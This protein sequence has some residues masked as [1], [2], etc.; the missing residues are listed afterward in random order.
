MSKRMTTTWR[1]IWLALVISAGAL[2]FSEQAL[3]SESI[4]AELVRLQDQT[5]LTIAW[6]DNN[7][8]SLSFRNRTPL[9]TGVRAVE[10]KKRAV[11]PLKDSLSAFRL[12]GF[13]FDNFPKFAADDFCWSH[14]RSMV[15]ATMLDPP[16]ASLGIFVLNSKLTQ[17][18]E[19]RAD[20]RM[21][22]TSQCWSPD[23]KEVTYEL[24][25]NVKIYQ[26]GSDASTRIRVLAKGTDVTWSPDGNWIAFRDHDTYY[27]I[28][29]D[30]NGRKELFRNHWGRAVSALYWS[31]DSRIVAY[32][33]EL[34][35][36]QG[37]ALDAEVNQSGLGGWMMGRTIDCARIAWMGMQT[38]I[39]FQRVS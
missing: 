12:D 6:V 33:R 17:A 31:P 34:G 38:I 36:L 14:D 26:I 2:F 8:L 21:H 28:H 30:G 5:G 25:G 1:G 35:F 10:F 15:A 22:F 13:R 32:V 7:V 19:P 39:G 3:S 16:E 24:E 9:S 4:H 37:G 27:A 23:D 11:V 29:P 18:I 20:H